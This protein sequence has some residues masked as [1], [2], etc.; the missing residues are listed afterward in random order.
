[1][2]IDDS[3]FTILYDSQKQLGLGESYLEFSWNASLYYA[4]GGC[5][6]TYS[7][8]GIV[9]LLLEQQGFEHRILDTIQ[10]LFA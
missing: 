8:V 7:H 5:T 1:M 6:E 4:S 10:Q 9:K 3:H 2:H